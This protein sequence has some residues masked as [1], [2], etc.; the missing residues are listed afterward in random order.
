VFDP[1]RMSS[2]AMDSWHRRLTTPAASV[3]PTIHGS[4]VSLIG[5]NAG[6]QQSGGDAVPW[7]LFVR[8]LITSATGGQ[9]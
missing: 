2:V 4:Y 1:G 3:V 8:N 9:R 5:F 6:G 7:S